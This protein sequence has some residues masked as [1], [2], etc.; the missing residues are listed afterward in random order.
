M[1][2]IKELVKVAKKYFGVGGA[3]VEAALKST[4]KTEFT[5]DEAKK[6]VSE[7]ANRPVK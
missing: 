1:Y 4:G 2:E 3:L 6:I 5:L 7:F